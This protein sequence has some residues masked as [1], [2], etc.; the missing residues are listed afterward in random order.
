MIDRV[1]V[2]ALHHFCQRPRIHAVQCLELAFQER[3]LRRPSHIS[4]EDRVIAAGDAQRR[5]E[6]RADLPGRTCDQY[7]FHFGSS[8]VVRRRAPDPP[9]HA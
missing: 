4:R 8:T 5:H 9:Q 1:G 3:A 6:L 2:V 7:S